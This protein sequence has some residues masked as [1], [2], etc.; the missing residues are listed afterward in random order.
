M[1][2][3]IL[4]V[5]AALWLA[6]GNGANDNFKGVATLYGSDTTTFRG[7]L[8][9]ATATTFA[10]SVVSVA[11]ARQLVVT[12]SGKGLVPDALA[13]SPAFAA[14]VG[15]GAALTIFIATFIGMPTST[16]HALIGGLL[17]T[18]LAAGAQIGTG[19]LLTKFAIPMLTSPI[20]AIAIA[21]IL[22]SIFKTVRSRSG[23]TKKTCVCVADGSLQPVLVGAN[24][25][26]T[27]SATG[28]ALD[29]DENSQCIERY[30][31]KVVGI[32]AQK[33]LDTM[34]YLSAGAVCFSRAV[35]DTPKIA[36]LLLTTAILPSSIG[37]G[38]IGIAVALGGIIQSRQVAET[39]S[40]RIT[41]L[42]PGQGF[43][44]NITTAALVLFASRLGVPVSTTHVSCGSIFGIGAANRSGRWNT[45]SK[46][47]TTWATTLP[48]AAVLSGGIYWLVR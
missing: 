29:I 30:Q 22:Y 1:A 2:L 10:G 14:S 25:V 19:V 41:D 46:I 44:A 35:N 32:D 20:L 28:L 15:L 12:F 8:W 5:A 7:A 24:G 47:L 13:S 33:S 26:M 38:L 45:I 18:G 21:A 16:T 6:Y 17:G 40:K 48:M 37:V 39:M 31:G 9:W 34:H 27:S 42:S 43:T 36:A 4:I 23:I 11:I 3:T